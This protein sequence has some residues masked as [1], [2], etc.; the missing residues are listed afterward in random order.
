VIDAIHQMCQTWGAQKAYILRSS[1]Q[2]WAP[3]SAIARFR[4]MRDGAGSST[5]RL[6]QFP[7]EGHTGEGLLVARAL[8]GAP[9]KLRVVVFVHYAVLRVKTHTK[10]E[11]LGLSVPMYWRT[12]DRAHYWIAARM[13]SMFHDEQSVDTKNPR[14]C[15]NECAATQ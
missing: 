9:E 2:G 15:I 11:E 5:Q 4:E 7:E 6:T 1:E 8:H 10:A 3:Q 14:S 13:P 12:L